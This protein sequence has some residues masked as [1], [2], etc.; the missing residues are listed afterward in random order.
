MNKRKFLK[1]AGAASV[2]AGLVLASPV[3]SGTSTSRKYEGFDRV[4]LGHWKYRKN[5]LKELPK[6]QMVSLAQA[7]F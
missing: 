5:G 6:V 4:P 7:S 3:E 2:A 1:Q